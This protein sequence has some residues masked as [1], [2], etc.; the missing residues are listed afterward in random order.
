MEE[1][2]APFNIN[3]RRF[4]LTYSQAANILP[5]SVADQLYALT[6]TPTF[7]EVGTEHHRDGGIHYHAVV[8]FDRRV[9]RNGDFF[10][11]RRFPDGT[12]KPRVLAIRNAGKDLYNRRHYIRKGDRLDDATHKP[13]S[14]ATVPCDYDHEPLLRGTAPTYAEPLGSVGWAGILNM[15]S[16]E[17]E[18]YRLVEEHQPADW[19]LR[20]NAVVSFGKNKFHRV[21]DFQARDPVGPEDAI[22]QIDDWILEVQNKVRHFGSELTPLP[23]WLIDCCSFIQVHHRQLT[24]V[25][26]GPTRIGKTTYVRN[27]VHHGGLRHMYMNGHYHLDEWD[28]TADVIVMD[29]LPLHLLRQRKQ[30]FGCQHEF[31]TEDKYR[32]KR[33]ISGGKPLI[34]VCNEENLPW[35]ARKDGRPVLGYDEEQYFRQNC[36]IVRVGPNKLYREY[37]FWVRCSLRSHQWSCGASAT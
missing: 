24:L 9:Q 35:N 3:G 23:F 12:C 5:E 7:V 16:T 34:W 22:P 26:C 6:P 18:F 8:V 1:I 4:F 19:V 2:P 11:L 29:D 30:W 20:H 37:F 25:V 27:A 31:V 36:T 10:W 33:K 14:H 21:P 13:K 17:D 15:A 32:V 28:P